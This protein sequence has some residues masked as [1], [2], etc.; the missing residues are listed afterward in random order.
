L[1]RNGNTVA[2]QSTNI[3]TAQLLLSNE[4]LDASSLSDHRRFRFQKFSSIW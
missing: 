4:K 3:D 2:V 1:K